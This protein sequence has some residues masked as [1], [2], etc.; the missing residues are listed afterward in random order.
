MIRIIE[1]SGLSA[2]YF[3]IEGASDSGQLSDN[4]EARRLA[5]VMFTDMTGYT[6]LTQRDESLALSLLEKQNGIVLPLIRAFG[7]T[8]VK[9]IGDA[10][11]A[12]FDNTLAAVRCALE[13]QRKLRE[14]NSATSPD[15]NFTL[16]IGVHVGDVIHKDNDVFGD[17]VNIA[18]RLQPIADPGGICVSQQVYD[19]IQNKAEFKLERLPAH[20][21]KNV[22]TRMNIYKVLAMDS[23][24]I[25]AE[26]NM[27]KERVAVLPLSNF[28]P[29]QQDEYLADGMTEE[30]ITAISAVQGLRVIARTSVMRFKNAGVDVAEIGRTLGVGTILE[31]S[32]RKAGERIRVTVQLIDAKTEEHI[33]ASNYDGDMQDIFSIQTDIANKVA[34]ALKV[35]LLEKVPPSQ[36]PV[37]IEAYELYLKGRSY[38]NRRTVEGVTQ[39]LKLFRLAVEKDPQFAKAYSGIADCYMVG[40]MLDLFEKEGQNEAEAAIRKALELDEAIAEAHASRGLLLTNKFQYAEA[41]EEFRRA[42]ALNQSYASAHHWYAMALAD[43]GRLDEAIAQAT[44]A[45]QSDPLSAPPSNVL[46]TMYIW[47]R[48]YDKALE[49]FSDILKREPDFHPTRRNRSMVY[50]LKG[51]EAE[52]MK[53]LER[54]LEGTDDFHRNSDF[55]LHMA[56]LGRN[57][58]ALKYF[59]QAEKFARSEK[60]LLGARIDFYAVSGDADAFFRLAGQAMELRY[61]TPQE[62]RYGPWLDKVRGDPRYLDLLKRLPA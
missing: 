47:A 45:S 9:T 38:W 29:S 40:L 42:L 30:L 50:L 11:L 2:N 26:S 31:G 34:Q 23:A 43:M 3:T 39:A 6:A 5:A 18:A 15:Q 12:E 44:L 56:W 8:P 58:E 7:G 10:H 13:I 22:S 32:F 4:L 48:D 1:E 20:Q 21:L 59:E 14:Y 61:L 36:K 24:K 17:A 19:Q 60:L 51:M 57:E 37:N 53:D 52:S 16:R 41:G 55:A 33:W 35:K 54:G 27:P 46:G 62:L 49:I 25:V 28:S